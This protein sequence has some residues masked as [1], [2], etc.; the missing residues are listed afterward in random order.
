VSVRRTTGSALVLTSVVLM[1]LSFVFVMLCLYIG[2]LSLAAYYRDKLHMLTKQ[3]LSCYISELS[4][5]GCAVP[6]ATAAA[7]QDKVQDEVN[8]SLRGMGMPAGTVTVTSVG[9]Q[10]TVTIAVNGL[11][12][13]SKNSFIPT[14]LDMQDSLVGDL[15]ALHPRG[16]VGLSVPGGPVVLVP[17]Y[18]RFTDPWSNGHADL[19]TAP[20]CAATFYN[21]NQAYDQYSVQFTGGDTYSD[22]CP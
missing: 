9:Q 7:A 2:N 13:I 18:G 4:W 20:Q 8:E 21:A 12:L 1:S 15:G 10:V 11:A 14:H 5:Y 16:T 3:A 6:G 17:T 19:R 22:N